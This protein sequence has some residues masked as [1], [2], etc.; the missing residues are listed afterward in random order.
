MNEKFRAI[1]RSPLNSRLTVRRIA[2]FDTPQ[3]MSK[4][5]RGA[6]CLSLLH[7]SCRFLVLRLVVSTGSFH[8]PN[9][10]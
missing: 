3:L 4:V 2:A 8:Y 7:G 10:S 6:C 5:S 1:G 9:R